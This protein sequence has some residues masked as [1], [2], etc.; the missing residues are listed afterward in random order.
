MSSF[1]LDIERCKNSLHSIESNLRVPSHVSLTHFLFHRSAYYLEDGLC[2]RFGIFRPTNKLLI[3]L[4]RFGLRLYFTFQ[5]FE[6]LLNGLKETGG[7]PIF[8]QFFEAIQ[9]GTSIIV[10]QRSHFEHLI[11]GTALASVE[12]HENEIKELVAISNHVLK[13]II[14]LKSLLDK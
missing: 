6:Q 14:D 10:R 8:G 1:L 13:D 12:L 4:E 9:D 7:N 5:D 3:S 2:V 11:L